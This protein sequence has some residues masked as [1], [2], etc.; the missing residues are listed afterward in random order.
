M[1]YITLKQEADHG[2]SEK[3]A[4]SDSQVGGTF[5]T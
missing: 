4:T 5:F 2:V 1:I 3:P